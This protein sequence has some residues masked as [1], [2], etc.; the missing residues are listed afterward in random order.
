MR[1]RALSTLGGT[2]RIGVFV[3]PFLGAAAMQLWG[4]P[5]AYY[6]SLVAI[7]AA[8]VIVYRVPDL[9]MSDQH[10][11]AAAQVT[12]RGILRRYWRTFLTLGTGILLLSAIRQT[13]QVVIPLWA[14]HIGLSAHR[15]LGHL[16]RRRGRRRADLLPGRQGDGRLRPPLGRRPVRDHHGHLVRPHAPHARRRHP[17][18]GRDDHGLR[19]RHRL[20]HRD[21]PRRR[22]LSRRSGA[23][24]SSASGA[25][26]P[27]PGRASALSSCPLSPPSPGWA[28]V[29]SSAALSG[30]PRRRRC[31]PG[32]RSAPAR[33]ARTPARPRPRGSPT[34]TGGEPPGRYLEQTSGPQPR[35]VRSTRHENRRFRCRL[36]RQCHRGRARRPRARGHRGV[37]V[38]GQ[39]RAS[40]GR[41]RHRE[42]PRPRVP[43]A[44]D[45]QGGRDRVGPARAQPRRRPR[46][47]RH[48]PPA[49][50]AGQR[51]PPRRRRR[52]LDHPRGRGRPPRR[53]HPRVPRQVRPAHRCP[54]AGAGHPER[55]AAGRRLVLPRPRGRVRRPQPR[56]PHRRLPHERHRPGHW[57][58]GHSRLGVADYAIAFADELE[59]PRTRRG[60][61]AIG[62]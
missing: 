20:G 19:Q 33:S 56:H 22:H 51:G 53:R 30:S 32:S 44:G 46:R 21:D 48:R 6:V 11:A 41:L 5:G 35:Q 43:R 59:T 42:R 17:R 26:W 50:R 1:A 3:G 25:S 34:P 52:R 60:W 7:A 29:S 58:D 61:L 9:E 2:L 15:Q 28:P 37:P 12:S 39:G 45:S 8:G 36:R 54:P 47:G 31:G 10:K 55:G 4:L 62:Y 27:T 38:R 57:P 40:S 13:R 16:R 23:P 49:G 24:P 18:T 14:A